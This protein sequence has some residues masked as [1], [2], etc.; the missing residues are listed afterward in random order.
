MD[1]ASADHPT[2]FPDAATSL[3]LMTGLRCWL[4]SLPSYLTFTYAPAMRHCCTTLPSNNSVAADQA[5]NQS[6]DMNRWSMLTAN[7]IMLIDSPMTP[8]LLLLPAQRLG[9]QLDDLLASRWLP[10][11]WETR[12][13]Q[14][15]ELPLRLER[16]V[17]ILVP[18][19]TWRAYT[20]SAQ[21]LCAVARGRSLTSNEATTALLDVRFLDSDAQVYAGGVWAYDLN[22]GW[23]LHAILDLA[24]IADRAPFRPEIVQA[25]PDPLQECLAYNARQRTLNPRR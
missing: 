25:P 24:G 12:I 4:I 23:R 10:A 22:S 6:P 14:L 2:R 13:H 21:I 3:L 1:A 16:C 9:A 11:T 5:A 19:T 17:R 8:R 20:D 15:C 7:D 18:G